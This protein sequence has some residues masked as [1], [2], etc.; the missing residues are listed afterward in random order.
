MEAAIAALIL[1]NME[2]AVGRLWRWCHVED[3]NH[4]LRGSLVWVFKLRKHSPGKG[5]M[6]A[7]T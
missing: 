5:Q 2:G 6:D 4:R 7:E 3:S 1:T